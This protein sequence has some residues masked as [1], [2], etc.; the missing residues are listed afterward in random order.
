[1]HMLIFTWKCDHY[2]SLQTHFLWSSIV[3]TPQKVSKDT[4]Y[5][6]IFGKRVQDNFLGL[7]SSVKVNILEQAD[8]QYKNIVFLKA[9]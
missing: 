2:K 3:Q 5:G 4:K 7:N 8:A 9:I 1:M 6:K